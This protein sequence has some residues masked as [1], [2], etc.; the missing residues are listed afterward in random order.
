MVGK[1]V[2]LSPE[3]CESE[4]RESETGIRV[5]GEFDG[6]GLVSGRSSGLWKVRDES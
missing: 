6:S 5:S 3:K 4:W 2:N 1:A